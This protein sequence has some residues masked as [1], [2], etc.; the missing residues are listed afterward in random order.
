MMTFLD[1]VNAFITE[2]GINGGQL[3]T[4][5]GGGTLAPG[6]GTPGQGSST[7]SPEVARV[8]QMIADAD[9]EIQSLH[10]DW[11][12]LWRQYRDVL[13]SG[14][15]V[16]NTPK[17]VS[18]S[19][20]G[21]SYPYTLRTIDR[22]SLVF[23]YGSTTQAF[24]PRYREWREFEALWQSRGAKNVS[25]YP[26]DWTIS[27]SGNPILSH[28]ASTNNL[29]YQYEFYIR[30]QRMQADGDVSPLVLAV[31]NNN[32]GVYGVLDQSVPPQK[33]SNPSTGGITAYPALLPYPRGN[34][35]LRYESCRIVIARAKIIWAE[36]EGATEIMQGALAEYQDLL[37]ELRADQ[38]PGMRTDRMSQDDIPM[39]V[40]TI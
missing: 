12:F 34:S 18:V 24:R 7:Y 19:Q 28:V 40:E 37:E 27:P 31:T 39:V 38:L 35:P 17:F 6:A 16:L 5:T 13:A 2:L 33:I 3:L 21:T 29:P 36:V 25:D 14:A 26:T 32:Q 20:L 15:D 8:C 11:R 10:H 1:L 23:N 30:P 9:Y 22:D 4:S